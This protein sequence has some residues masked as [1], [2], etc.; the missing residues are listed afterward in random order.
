MGTDDTGWLARRRWYRRLLYGVLVAGIAGFVLAGRVGRP[1]L[2]VAI[3]WTAFLGFLGVR[4]FSPM[5][6]FDERDVALERRASYDALRL[7]GVALI[8]G[9][10]AAFVLAEA[11]F[12]GVS[13][14]P[15]RIE[16]VLLGYAGLFVAFGVAYLARRYRP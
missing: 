15:P 13:E 3:Y 10:P 14:A 7:A 9:A 1:L 4:R 6:L 11:G 5:V 8:V 12:D 16:G 2:A